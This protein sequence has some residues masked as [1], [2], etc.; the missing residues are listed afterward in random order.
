MIVLCY[1]VIRMNRKDGCVFPTKIN[2]AHQTHLSRFP[3]TLLST[4]KER[5]EG[6]VTPLG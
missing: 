2:L 5:T 1:G 4:G 6:S 3:P